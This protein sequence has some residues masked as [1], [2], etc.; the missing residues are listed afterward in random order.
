MECSF[1]SIAG[2]G[3]LIQHCASRSA[4]VP[5]ILQKVAS[6]GPRESVG[7]EIIRVSGE[8]EKKCLNFNNSYTCK[9]GFSLSITSV[10]NYL[11]WHKSDCRNISNYRPTIPLQRVAPHFFLTIFGTNPSVTRAHWFWK[12]NWV[13]E[14]K[15]GGKISGRKHSNVS[16]CIFWKMHYSFVKTNTYIFFF[17]SLWCCRYLVARSN[18]NK[19]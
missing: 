19:V 16:I 14:L 2:T 7:M 12:I 8:W 15:E 4:F 13:T 10:K 17:L 9:W 5:T 6:V 11:R 18:M 3:G 1:V